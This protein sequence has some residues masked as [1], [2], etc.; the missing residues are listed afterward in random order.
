MLSQNENHRGA[1]LMSAS[2]AAFV[3]N[4]ALMKSV[5]G[6]VGL[7]QAILVR[8]VIVTLL[9]GAYALYK[10]ALWP[11]LSFSDWRLLALRSVGEVGSTLCFLTALFH[12]PLANAIAI[13]QSMPLAVTLAAAVFLG[14]PVGW[15]RYTAIAVG[16]VGVLLIVQPTGS[17]FNQYSLLAVAAV[18]FL[19]LRDLTTR[20]M[21][22]AVP[23]VFVA[24]TAAL[25]V[26]LV[27]AS[28][29]VVEPWAPLSTGSL[30]ALASA[31]CFIFFGYTCAVM[32]MRVG[33]ISFV[34]SFRY[35]ILLWALGLGY[36]AFG[37]IPDQLS[38]VGI[39]IVTASG[40]YTFYRE[41]NLGA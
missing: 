41:R 25:V 15:R 21:S 1:F 26:L 27:G 14:V 20:Q 38:L 9:I 17:G 33:D 4:D 13:L 31:A 12:M 35:T 36:F 10:G 8:G 7:Y 22:A 5:S 6:E 23:S 11:R 34:S 30:V 32:A 24:F 2:M 28:V 29:S 18:L 19:V 16:F 40:L 3:F 37:D 39:A